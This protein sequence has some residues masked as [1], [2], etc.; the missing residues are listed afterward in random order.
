MDEIDE[1][2]S[3]RAAELYYDE[4]KTQDEIGRRCA[5]SRWKV[6]RLLAQAQERGI[7]R[8]EIVHPRA[9]RLPV[10][11]GSATSAAS[12]DAIVVSDAG[13][14]RPKS[15]RRAPPRPPPTTSPPCARC[16]APSASAGGAPSTRSRSTS[17]T[18]WAT[19]VTVVQINGGVSLNRRAGTAAAMAV[20]IAQ[21]AAGRPCC[22]R[23]PRSSSASRPSA[24]SRPT[25]R[26]P[27][28]STRAAGRRLSVQRRRRRR[29]ARCSSTAATCA[30]TMSPSSCA[31]ARSATSSAATSTPTAT[32][33][34]PRSTSVRSDWGSTSC[35]RRQLAIFVDGGHGQARRRAAVVISGLCTV[36]VTDEGTA[37]HSGGRAAMQHRGHDRPGQHHVRHLARPP[38]S[39]RSSCS[40]ASPTTTTLR[41]YLHGLPGVD[42]VGLEQRA[43]GLGT[44]SIKTT[45][46]AWALDT[47]HRAHRPDDPRGRRHPRQGALARREGAEARCRRPD[48]ARASPRCASTAT[49]CRTPSR[50]SAPRTAIRTTG[51]SRSPRS[52]PRSRAAARRSR[53]SSPT[54]RT[55]SRAGADEIDMVIDRG[56]FLAGRYGLV[57]DQ[58]VA[59][60][61]GVPPRRRHLRVAS[62]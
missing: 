4:N 60:Q 2:L 19:G 52:P 12:T 22:C 38:E 49:W 30:P 5:L 11:R 24:R 42:A 45:S 58:I 57:F 27:T 41:R 14:A 55:P 48:D 23:A 39:A 40:A 54:P 56:A 59:R 33:S 31:R 32:S 6:G 13:V 34:T 16:R 51:S 9:R 21:R 3:I 62:R 8:I 44:R 46:K 28:C 1:L 43:A 37:L 61:G 7:V 15:C 47:H 36:L 25:A 18:G 26:S 53:S 29:R 17:R 20:A 10:E 35:A 50:R